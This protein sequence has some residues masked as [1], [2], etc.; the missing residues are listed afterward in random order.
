MKTKG[1]KNNRSES[2]NN[3]FAYDTVRVAAQ[4]TGGYEVLQ[5]RRL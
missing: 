3:K 4:S 5:S 2:S 1:N